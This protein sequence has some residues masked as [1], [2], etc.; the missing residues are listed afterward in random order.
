[1]LHSEADHVLERYKPGGSKIIPR[2]LGLKAKLNPLLTFQL[3]QLFIFK[4]K[5]K[6]F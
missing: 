5:I 1:M 6:L 3:I 4:N 2:G